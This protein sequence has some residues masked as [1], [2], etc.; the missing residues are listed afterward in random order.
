MSSN[1]DMIACWN[2][3]AALRGFTCKTPW[4]VH[5]SRSARVRRR[6][7]HFTRE[8]AYSMWDVDADPRRSRWLS[9]WESAER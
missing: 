8:S 6:R 5:S 9:P 4:T 2:A 1:V 7:S 3:Q